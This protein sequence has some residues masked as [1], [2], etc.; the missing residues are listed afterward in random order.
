MCLLKSAIWSLYAQS[1][2]KPDYTAIKNKL[3][4]KFP[5]LTEHKVQEELEEMLYIL[6]D[7]ESKYSL[8]KREYEYSKNRE[9]LMEEIRSL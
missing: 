3:V 7:E 1:Q 5:D 9:L 6:E 8:Y 2:F 4:H